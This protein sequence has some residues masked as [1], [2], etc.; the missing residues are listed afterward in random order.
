MEKRKKNVEDGTSATR[1]QMIFFFF[2]LFPNPNRPQI[3]IS[4]LIQQKEKPLSNQHTQT[5]QPLCVC[6]CVC[7]CLTDRKRKQSITIGQC[8]ITHT[9][10]QIR[11]S[12]SR[13]AKTLG[14]HFL[15]YFTFRLV[16]VCI[17]IYFIP[18]FSS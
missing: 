9:R 16:V 15:F 13:C 14:N 5:L 3:I 7:V 4:K 1:R 18:A 11:I 12:I 2:W 17:K 10:R 6:V 8:V